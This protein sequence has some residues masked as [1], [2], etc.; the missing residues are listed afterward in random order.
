MITSLRSRGNA[1]RPTMSICP[2]LRC[3]VSD[4][5]EY[6]DTGYG[7]LRLAQKSQK[8]LRKSRGMFVGAEPPPYRECER[9][10]DPRHCWRSSTHVIGPLP[11]LCLPLAHV[12]SH[13]ACLVSIQSRRFVLPPNPLLPFLS[14]VESNTLFRLFLRVCEV[15]M[16][17]LRFVYEN[18]EGTPSALYGVRC[19]RSPPQGSGKRTG[20]DNSHQPGR[21]PDVTL[22]RNMLQR[23]T[24]AAE[25][26]MLSNCQEMRCVAFGRVRTTS[27]ITNPSAGT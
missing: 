14:C 12:C 7:D 20:H 17:T 8:S 1:K 2:V 18:Y 24:R 4:L 10:L 26:P 3:T 13:L 16:T 21:V 22:P 11:L 5:R 15:I 25:R 27:C 6:G 9:C 23:N 19:D